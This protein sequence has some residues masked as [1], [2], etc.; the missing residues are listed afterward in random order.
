MNITL[1]GFGDSATLLA[2]TMGILRNRRNADVAI[3][4]GYKRASRA[5]LNSG[6]YPIIINRPEA[7]EK[8][9]NKFKALEIMKSAGVPV[10]NFSRE[11][12]DLSFPVLGRDNNHVK[13]TDIKYYAYDVDTIDNE[14][15]YYI[16]FMEI[17]KERRY[18]VID[19]KVVTATY[20]QNGETTGRGAYCRNTT[21]GWTFKTYTAEPALSEIAI[22]AVEAFGLDFGAVDI[23][24]SGGRPYVLEVNTAPGLIPLRVDIY[25][26][27]LQKLAERLYRGEPRET[28]PVEREY[29]IE[30]TLTGIKNVE[31]FSEE[32]AR[33]KFY[34]TFETEE[35]EV[36]IDD[37]YEV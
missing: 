19:G 35:G 10:P 15:E 6:R 20:K 13:G 4:Y 16:E 27:K 34:D 1:I 2:D 26:E 14:S 32:E 25:A 8:S 29:C 22:K 24:I 18:H 33:E 30:Y 36:D 37:I 5:R 17:E 3:S 12:K 23:L 9:S 11:W 21:T 7:I 28:T 31:A